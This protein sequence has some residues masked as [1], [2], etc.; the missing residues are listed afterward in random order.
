MILPEAGRVVVTGSVAFDYL[1][2]FPGHFVEHLIPD[3]MRRLV[4]RF[5]RSRSPS[6][7]KENF[8]QTLYLESTA[9]FVQRVRL[10]DVLQNEEI[11]RDGSGHAA[12][13]QAA[14]H[15]QVPRFEL[16]PVDQV[17]RGRARFEIVDRASLERAEAAFDHKAAVDQS[18][19]RIKSLDDEIKTAQA[20]VAATRAK[21]EVAQESARTALSSGLRG[22]SSIRISANDLTPAACVSSVWTLCACAAA[23]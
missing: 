3:E 1:M 21:L 22:T 10:E 6:V 18:E 9:L 19:G 8:N 11:P 17:R 15:V 13:R 16:E 2:R 7:M 5:L 14:G 4:S 12:G 23:V 20:D